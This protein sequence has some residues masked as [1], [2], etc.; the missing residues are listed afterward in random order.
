MG[1]PGPRGVGD[2]QGVGVLRIAS[3]QGPKAGCFPPKEGGEDESAELEWDGGSTGEKCRKGRAE[4]EGLG[5]L[6]AEESERRGESQREGDIE[7]GESETSIEKKPS[8][9]LGRLQR[10]G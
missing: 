7:G 5:R 10:T 4:K 1:E 2:E 3:V 6:Q 9:L 8:N